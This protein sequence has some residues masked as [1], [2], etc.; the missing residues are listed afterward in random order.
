MWIIQS[1]EVIESLA[2]N[3]INLKTQFDNAIFDQCETRHTHVLI[4]IHVV[5]QSLDLFAVKL[6]IGFILV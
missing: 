4:I 5:E 3:S 6:L 2:T 1:A